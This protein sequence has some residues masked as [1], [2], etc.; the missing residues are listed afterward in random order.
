MKHA[1]YRDMTAS[2]QEARVPVLGWASKKLLRIF[3]AL[4]I[5]FPLPY[6]YVLLIEGPERSI[7]IVIQRKS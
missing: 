5:D 1:G 4:Q 7:S 6:L 2:T 3:R